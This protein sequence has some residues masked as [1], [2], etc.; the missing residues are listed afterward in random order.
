M[1][2]TPTDRIRITLS[3]KA[4]EYLEGEHSGEIY[5]QFVKT[6]MLGIDTIEV[7]GNFEKPNEKEGE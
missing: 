3:E 4:S 5:E 1:S 6:K 7:T 2:K